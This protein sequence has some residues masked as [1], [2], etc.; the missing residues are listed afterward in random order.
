MCQILST[1]SFYAGVSQFFQ[2]LIASGRIQVGID[3]PVGVQTGAVHPYLEKDFLHE[4]F[5]Q[6][7]VLN[8]A[9][10]IVSEGL[11]VLVEQLFIGL[12]IAGADFPYPA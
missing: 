12:L 4:V 8:E 2:R 9:A 6:L 10:G 5:R 1:L 7:G 11:A 3:I